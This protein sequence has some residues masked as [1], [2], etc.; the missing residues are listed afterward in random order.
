[1]N[2]EINSLHALFVSLTG[3]DLTLDACGYR[4]RW[5]KQKP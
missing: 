1:M 5:P 4:Y 2:A 3:R